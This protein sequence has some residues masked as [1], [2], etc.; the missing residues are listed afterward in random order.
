MSI[1]KMEQ[2]VKAYDWYEPSKNPFI[3]TIEVCGCRACIKCAGTGNENFP[4]GGQTTSDNYYPCATCKGTGKETYFETK[5][6]PYY[7]QT[8]DIIDKAIDAYKYKK[9]VEQICV[10]LM[11]IENL[12]L[13]II[14][15]YKTCIKTYEDLGGDN[16][17]IHIAKAHIKRLERTNGLVNFNN[18]IEK[19]KK[20]AETKL[21]QEKITSYK[22]ALTILERNSESAFDKKIISSSRNILKD[23]EESYMKKAILNPV[24]EGTF[25]I[26]PPKTFEHIPNLHKPQTPAITIKPVKWNE[27]N[28]F[29]S[30]NGGF[31]DIMGRHS[32]MWGR[33]MAE[34]EK[35]S[36]MRQFVSEYR[37]Y[38]EHCKSQGVEPDPIPNEDVLRRR[39]EWITLSDGSR[40][41]N[42]H[43]DP[44]GCCIM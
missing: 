32:E 25:K 38:A 7:G 18:K 1:N 15:T 6:N 14:E 2:T 3:K 41:Y 26:P 19:Y 33:A 31:V 44:P 28:D 29:E 21:T 11:K 24:P 4:N 37:K 39:L 22:N 42:K 5:P 27:W 40:I 34:Q 12:K 43:Y 20:E 8:K 16:P 30:D 9:E 36:W 23:I 17:I 10:N 35:I 13:N